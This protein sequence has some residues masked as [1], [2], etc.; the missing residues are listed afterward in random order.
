[1]ASGADC[2]FIRA[3]YALYKFH[4]MGE[5][6]SPLKQNSASALPAFANGVTGDVALHGALMSALCKCALGEM[7]GCATLHTG[8][9]HLKTRLF[10]FPAHQLN[11]LSFWQAKLCFYGI[12]RR[13][14]FPC[15]FYDAVYLLWC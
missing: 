10:H 11:D 9:P 12:K 7:F 4:L 15:H 13:A 3:F 14:V 5:I 8:P 6:P 1:M 2:P